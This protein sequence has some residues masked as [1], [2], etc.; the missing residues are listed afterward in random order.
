[1]EK[2][3][4]STLTTR[5]KLNISGKEMLTSCALTWYPDKGTALFGSILAKNT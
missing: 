5:S 3:A 4:G 1:M 2:L